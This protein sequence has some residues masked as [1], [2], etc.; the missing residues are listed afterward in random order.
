VAGKPGRDR[1]T[2][3]EL[4]RGQ[5]WPDQKLRHRPGR[6]D[7]FGAAAEHVQLPHDLEGIGVLPLEHADGAMSEGS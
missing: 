3:P 1:R 2:R 6:A 4:N 5:Q 7:A